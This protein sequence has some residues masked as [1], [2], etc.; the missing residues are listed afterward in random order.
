M[1]K[2]K[3]LKKGNNG[4]QF[5]NTFFCVFVTFFILTLLFMDFVRMTCFKHKNG[6]VNSF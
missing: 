5:K 1:A 2:K 3:I 4:N 6:G